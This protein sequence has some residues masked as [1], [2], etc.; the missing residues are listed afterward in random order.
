MALRRSASLLLATALLGLAA[1]SDA[2]HPQ[3]GDDAG[4]L[5]G[6]AGVAEARS[7]LE[8]VEDGVRG[9][10]V[11]ADLDADITAAEL[12]AIL[13]AI[14]KAEP[15]RYR[16]SLG[17]GKLPVDVP[18]ELGDRDLIDGA[19]SPIAPPADARAEQFLAAAR[20]FD[21]SVELTPRGTEVVLDHGDPDDVTSAL[22]TTLADPT[23]RSTP[24]LSVRTGEPQPAEAS[25]V[26]FAAPLTPA[27]LEHWR[28][29]RATLD[30]APAGAFPT[31]WLTEGRIDEGDAPRSI[32]ARL[33]LPRVT[34]PGTV[35]PTTWGDRLWPL[36]HAQLDVAAALGHRTDYDLRNSVPP[37]GG[38]GLD[39]TDRLVT[40]T[41]GRGVGRAPSGWDGPAAAYLR[42]VT[43]D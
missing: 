25:G 12:T 24:R 31:V 18:I 30:L 43:S 41:V 40:V 32:S 35:T 9:L 33:T 36:I 15:D 17:W 28:G 37:P 34:R 1:C 11:R 21:G 3:K 39:E 7:G 22:E 5:S 23:L 27:G 2:D 16:L 26:T 10:V 29:L 6:L 38:E 14:E 8:E 42:S 13:T 20:A 19:Y 4:P